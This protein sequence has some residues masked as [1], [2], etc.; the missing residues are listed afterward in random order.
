MLFFPESPRWLADN[1]RTEEAHQ[2]LA[3][4]HGKGQKNDALVLEEIHEIM[5]AVE[6]DKTQA[7]RSY[8]DLLKDGNLRRL[9]LGC[10][11]Q[12]WAQVSNPIHMTIPLRAELTL[13]LC[14]QAHR[15]ER[16]SASSVRS[17]PRRAAD[18]R[19][20]SLQVMMYFVVSP[21]EEE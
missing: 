15:H 2:I 5:E 12:M 17:R 10:S 8:G 21:L 3:D 9:V 13:V 16:P 11:V 14:V 20:Y 1:G 6:F 18:A 19:I 4:L 7:A